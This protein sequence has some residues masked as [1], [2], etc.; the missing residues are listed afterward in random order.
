MF[1][2]QA[3]QAG[4]PQ[5]PDRD[6]RC[7]F[8]SPVQVC[9]SVG[10][11]SPGIWSRLPQLRSLR[12]RTLPLCV[13]GGWTLGALCHRGSP[14]PP[15]QG[16]LQQELPP[17]SHAAFTPLHHAMCR[18][19][20]LHSHGHGVSES[21]WWGQGSGVAGLKPHPQRQDHGLGIW[22]VKTRGPGTLEGGE[23]GSW[24]RLSQMLLTKPQKGQGH[25]LTRLLCYQAW[26]KLCYQSALGK[27][28]WKVSAY[29]T[30]REIQTSVL[31]AEWPPVPSSEADGTRSHILGTRSS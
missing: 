17:G 4:K 9:L 8:T 31:Q 7:L 14:T 21:S 18:C 22:P 28:F 11:I 3:G 15:E 23:S 6:R 26:Q 13:V 29:R 16:G 5:V 12:G 30:L 24:S 1:W 27:S 2:P 10:P 19:G 25:H 20:Q